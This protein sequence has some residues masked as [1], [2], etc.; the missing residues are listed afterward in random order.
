MS[1]PHVGILGG[2]MW[3]KHRKC[4]ISPIH[5]YVTLRPFGCAQDKLRE[6]SRREAAGFF[7]RG[8]SAPLGHTVPKRCSFGRMT[9]YF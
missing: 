3:E 7:G 5:K 2:E 9:L 4:L 1:S 6:E 8:A